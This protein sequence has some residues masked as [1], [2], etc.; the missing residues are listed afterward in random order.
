MR[1]LNLLALLFCFAFYCNHTQAAAVSVSTAQAVALNF[2][3]FT[4]PG[5]A[6]ATLTPSLVYT[7]AEMDGSVD[8]YVFN[9]PPMTGFVIVSGQDVTTPILGY[10]AEVNFTAT[11]PAFAAINDWVK[12]AAIRVHY[13]A[14]NY[15]TANS[16]VQNL[17]AEIIAGQN[18]NSSRATT[19]GPLMVTTWNQNPYYNAEC[20]P[21]ADASTS[22]AKSVTGCVAT[23]IAQVM[24]YWNYPAAGTGGTYSYSDETPHYSENY[25]TLSTNLDRPLYWSAM[26]NS[27]TSNTSPID[28]LMYEAGVSVD[29]DYDPDGS[30]AYVRQAEAGTGKPCA[31]YSYLNYF[32]YNSA[33]M[34]GVVKSSYTSANWVTLMET[35][36]NAGRVVEYEGD[37]PSQGGHTWVLDGYQTSTTATGGALVHMN[38]GWGG[39][40]DGY[41]DVSNLTTTNDGFDPIDDDAALIGIEPLVSAAVTA[42]TV[43]AG[44]AT[45]LTVTTGYPTGITYAW[46]PTTGLGCSTCVTTSVTPTATTTYTVTAS[47]AGYGTIGT[48]SVVINVSPLPVAPASVT[49]PTAPCDGATAIYTAATVSG[50]TSYTWSV[51]GTG[52]S[53]T[54]ATNIATL[55]AGSVTGNVSVTANNA[56]GSGPAYTFTA[57][58]GAGPPAPASVTLPTAPCNGSTAVYTVPAVTGATSYTWSVS[59][60][61][62]SG[63]GTTNSATLTA[64]SVAGTVSVTANNSCGSSSAYVFA[65]PIGA[66]PSAPASVTLPGTPC[67]GAAA[68]YTV[69]VVSGATSYTWTVSGTGWSGTSSTNSISLIAGSVEGS[70]SVTANNSC[71]SSSAYTFNAPVNLPPAAPASVTLPGTPCSAATAVYTVAAVSGATSYTWTVSGTGWSGT[72]TTNSATLT[73]GSVAGSISVKANNACGAS[74]AYTF[75]AP[76]NSKPA[77]PTS[78]T[79]PTAPCNGATAIYTIPTVTSAT[80]YT[81][82]VSGSGWSGSSSTNSATLTAGSVSGSVSVTA[83]N[84][85]GSSS[86]Y[87]FTAPIGAGPSAPSSVTLPTAPCHG[88]TAIYTVAAVS[89]ATSYTWTVTGTGW[90]GSSTTNSATLTAGTVSGSVSVTANNAC[91]SSSAYVFTAPLG[92]GPSAPSSVTLPTAPCNGLT[93]VYTVPAVS[94]AT[95]YTWSVSGTGWSGSSTTNSATLTAG[96]VSGSVSVTANNACGSSSAYVFT[97]PIGAGPTAPTSATLPGTPCAGATAVYTVPVVAGA[98]SYTWTVTGTGWSGSSTTNSVTLTAGSVAGS[99]SVKANNACGSSSAYTFNAPVN[100]PPAAPSSVTLPTAPC[101]GATATYTIP[102]VSGATSY[103]WSVTGTGWSGSSTTTSA[104]LTAGSVAGTVSVKANNACGAGAAYVFTAPHATGPSAPASVTLPATPCQGSTAIYTIPAVSGATSYTWA[105]SGTGWSGTGTTTSAT[106]TAGSVDGTVSVTANNTCGSSTPYTFTVTSN[107]V[108]AEP[109]SVTLPTAPCT[110]ATATYTI[111]IVS[112]VTS[113]TWAVSGTGWSGA[114][115]TNSITLTAGSTTGS[116]SVTANNACGPGTAYVFAAPHAVGPS[117]PTSVTLP[118][119]PCANSTA[120]YTVPAVSGATSYTWTV[121]GTGWSGTGTT[122]SAT[123][124]AGSIAGSVTVTANNTCGPS[125]PYTFNAPVNTPPAA[126]ASVTLPSATCSNASATYTIPVVSGATSYTWS[127]SGSGWSGSSATNSI[128]LTAGAGTGTVSVSANNTCGS[129]SAYVFTVT[130]TASITATPQIN[131]TAVCAGSAANYSVTPVSGATSY[132]WQVSG[133]GWS[134]SS[135]TS[136]IALT[137]GTGTATITCI[138]ENAC[139]G[140]PTATVSVTPA[141]LPNAATS[142]ATPSLLC[143]GDAGTFTTP[144]IANATGYIWTISGTGWSGA[145][146]T[147]SISVFEGTTTGTITV[148]GQNACGTGTPFTLA[149][150]AVTP[151]PSAAFLLNTTNT[152]VLSPVTATFSGSASGSATYTWTFDGGTGTPGTGTG[153]QSV[154]WGSTGVKYITLTVSVNGCTSEY[155]DSVDVNKTNGIK[156]INI[157]SMDISIMP[158]PNNGL[159][160]VQFSDAVTRPLSITLTDVEGRQVYSN[161]FDAF[162][163][164]VSINATNLPSAIYI[165]TIE[166]DGVIVNKKI[167]INK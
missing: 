75:N 137:A 87:V 163:T 120:I 141:L 152:A 109:G 12:S 162:A 19:V 54:S 91:G 2:F 67:A 154:S 105:V 8:F 148:E 139:G 122:T 102:A 7:K 50:A 129:S 39:Y 107:P 44:V 35:E 86:A 30:G 88:S 62:W 127:V 134:G 58:I 1:K 96:S 57:P 100:L 43:C 51:S 78:V 95:S 23:T 65:A 117:A 130:P 64:G 81:W 167:V 52:W 135:T 116:V 27:T 132:V 49:L 104:T 161:Q 82:T 98:T 4:A 118:A 142:I 146:T 42:P 151:T 55:T 20:P 13:A 111:P 126:P 36:I 83:N 133:T 18:P 46:S 121:S 77:A 147:N 153:P 71:A 136:S 60:I 22:N 45:Q 79:L 93:A 166:C 3:K 40:D 11:I 124:T 164:K 25:G 112:G 5:A 113:Y 114:S 70:V 66:G 21:L 155:I 34:Q 68:V 31:Q 103:T 10:S 92:A 63:T 143:S 16:T 165:A 99:V 47:I 53:G 69:P 125:A 106:L 28:S 156:D 138:A 56:C 37:D 26:G 140:S 144:A 33:T 149:N 59:G 131:T 89:G 61:G 24:K 150:V 41:F 80:S 15:P 123:L 128:S 85:C 73:A 14:T 9:L 72:S 29:M 17:W 145:S 101:T 160:D 94:G 110:G 157:Q 158:N 115:T 76:I 108:P 119:T 90:S 6:N 74:T 32:K 159:F 84:A 38:W 97:A 48:A